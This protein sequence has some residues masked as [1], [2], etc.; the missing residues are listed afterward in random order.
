ML[1]SSPLARGP[2][3]HGIE[4]TARRGLIPARAGTTH[5]I[6]DPFAGS[7]AHPRSRGDHSR[8]WSVP[9]CTAGSSPLARGPLIP[10]A[11]VQTN[12]GLIPARAGTTHP[13]CRRSNAR[14]AHPRSR[15]DHASSVLK[16]NGH[17]G[18]SPLARGPQRR[19]G[20]CK[21]G[22]GLIPARAGTTYRKSVQSATMWAHPR[23][24][25]DHGP[26][27]NIAGGGAG[28][29]PLARGPHSQQNHH[30]PPG[31]LIPARAGTTR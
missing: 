28:S 21:H 14:R 29:S 1:G 20:I 2:L 15:G 13:A 3:P 11:Q 31:G 25:G 22:R 30:N 12:P 4:A 18:S 24:R 16:L 9:A 27:K 7:G 19:M 8:H 10:R 6:A 26:V 23:S 17:S 5:V